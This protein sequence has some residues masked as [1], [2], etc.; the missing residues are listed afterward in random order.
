MQCI[1]IL[2]F[3]CIWIKL[4]YI[5]MYTQYAIATIFKKNTYYNSVYIL[6]HTLLVIFHLI[7]LKEQFAISPTTGGP[8]DSSSSLSASAPRV[9]MDGDRSSGSC[10]KCTVR[11]QVYCLGFWFTLVSMHYFSA[12][13]VISSL[14]TI[15]DSPA[16]LHTQRSRI[17]RS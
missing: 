14:I 7:K 13:Q 11:L 16:G 4:L 5:I 12:S 9:A 15:H 2:Q 8:S 6:C 10:I 1:N 3:Y 17:Q